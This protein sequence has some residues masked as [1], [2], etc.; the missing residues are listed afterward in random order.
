MAIGRGVLR[1]LETRW[2]GRADRFFRNRHHGRF[3]A[4][5][6]AVSSVWSKT[7]LGRRSHRWRRSGCRPLLGCTPADVFLYAGQPV[8][9]AARNRRVP[10]PAIA[11][12]TTAVSAVAES[13]RRICARPRS[14]DRL[15]RR[16]DIGNS[17]RRYASTSGPSDHAAGV[18]ASTGLFSAGASEPWRGSTL[19]LSFLYPAITSDAVT[20]CRVV[21]AGFSSIALSAQLLLLWL[22]YS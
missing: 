21:L 17:R 4:A 1:T 19:S 22:H 5:L 3:H 14:A 13:A 15:R 18:A 6:P 11:L 12:D 8:Y 7:A 2:R 10:A 20:H 16:L 9:L